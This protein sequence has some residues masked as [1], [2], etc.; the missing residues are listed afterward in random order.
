MHFQWDLDPIRHLNIL[1][2]NPVER[3]YYRM[4]QRDHFFIINQKRYFAIYQHSYCGFIGSYTNQTEKISLNA[5]QFPIH[6]Q[7]KKEKKNHRLTN[8]APNNCVAVST[9]IAS[10]TEDIMYVAIKLPHQQ[11]QP[12][13]ERLGG[14]TI[15]AGLYPTLIS[16]S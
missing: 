7:F 16:P 9:S 5:I 14:L 13:H 15:K 6:L 3:P 4:Q 8:W 11:Q 10:V 2:L 1:L 12:S